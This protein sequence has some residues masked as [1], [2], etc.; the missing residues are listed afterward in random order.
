VYDKYNL[1][2]IYHCNDNLYFHLIF[3]IFTFFFSLFHIIV[4]LLVIKC[5]FEISFMTMSTIMMTSTTTTTTKVT[6]TTM[7]KWIRDIVVF[8]YGNEIEPI[9]WCRDSSSKAFVK[10]LFDDIVVGA[11]SCSNALFLSLMA[12]LRRIASK[13]HLYFSRSFNICFVII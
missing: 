13:L 10:S 4:L 2:D 11:I 1:N 6:T 3:L 9:G 5:L 8:T 7:K 12:S